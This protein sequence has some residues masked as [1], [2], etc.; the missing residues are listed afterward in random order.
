M[1][2][3]VE[4]VAKCL[5]VTADRTSS[6]VSLIEQ[7]CELASVVD[8]STVHA[9]DTEIH[10]DLSDEARSLLKEASRDPDGDIIVLRTQGGMALRTNGKHFGEIGDPQKE[11]LWIAT[12]K[13]LATYD[14]IE[15]RQ[16][17]NEVFSVTN[18][19]FKVADEFD[20]DIAPRPGSQFVFGQKKSRWPP[21]G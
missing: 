16:G 15:D 18:T 4:D 20:S 1:H 21:M 3:L 8:N 19:G 7:I 11:A 9:S 10:L 12:L 2:R 5:N 6:F 13:E 14:L 17:N